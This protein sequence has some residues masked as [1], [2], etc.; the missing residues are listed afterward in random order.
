MC[1]FSTFWCGF[2]SSAAFMHDFS[3]FHEEDIKWRTATDNG[4]I[5]L[6]WSENVCTCDPDSV[7]SFTGNTQTHTHTHTH[8]HIQA[9]THRN[10]HTHANTH[11]HTHTHT[12]TRKHAHRNRVCFTIDTPTP[13]N[14]K[15]IGQTPESSNNSPKQIDQQ[16]LHQLYWEFEL[17]PSLKGCANLVEISDIFSQILYECSLRHAKDPFVKVANVMSVKKCLPGECSQAPTR[18][19]CVPRF[20]VSI[21]PHLLLVCGVPRPTAWRG[22][23]NKQFMKL[24]Y[25]STFVASSIPLTQFQSWTLSAEM[26]IATCKVKT[27]KQIKNLCMCYTF[28]NDTFRR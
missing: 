15:P 3:V 8:T 25:R 19:P 11:T 1:N 16:T 5:T 17:Q 12:H 13:K 14:S 10:T 6:V 18:A 2:Y 28:G 20:N 9:H 27:R 24:H 21:R 22:N 26:N 23:N 7:H 4:L